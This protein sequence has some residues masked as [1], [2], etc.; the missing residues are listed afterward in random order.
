M[1]SHKI[2]TSLTHHA[3]SLNIRILY[4]FTSAI[5]FS[6]LEDVVPMLTVRQQIE[7]ASSWLLIPLRYARRKFPVV[8]PLC[9]ERCTNIDKHPLTPSINLHPPLQL[10][11]QLLLHQ[12]CAPQ[13]PTYT[14]ITSIHTA[15]RSCHWDGYDEGSCSSPPLLRSWP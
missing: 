5:S 4:E 7:S 6:N 2:C 10:C 8:S 1:S 3:N 14:V 15:N 9:T 12:Q 11:L 13:A